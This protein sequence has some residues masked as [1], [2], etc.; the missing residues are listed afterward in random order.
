MLTEPVNEKRGLYAGPDTPVPLTGVSVEAE[1][2]GFS[3]HV[4]VTQRYVNHE[5][6]P[7]EAVYVFPLDES[8]AV[9]GFEAVIDGSVVAGEV[10]ERDEAFRDYD[11]ALAAGHGAF[12][13]DEERPDVFTASIGNLR[14][15]AEVLV[16][17]SYVAELQF[18]GDALR[19]ALPTTLSPR[20]VPA[21]H[22]HGAAGIDADRVNPPVDWNVPYGLTLSIRLALPET[23]TRIESPSHPIVVS[24]NNRIATIALSEADAPLDRDFLLLVEAPA[25][26]EPHAWI[27]RDDDGTHAIAV[28]FCPR[29]PHTA[30]PG[31]I[32]FVVDR[33]GSMGGRSIAEV[34]NAL[35]LCLRSMTPGS[36]FNIVGFGSRFETLYPASRAYD[37]ASLAAASAHVETLDAD[38]GGTEILPALQFALERPRGP[39]DRQ[40]IVLTDGQVTNTD[41][42]LALARAHADSARIFTFGIGPGASHHLVRGL[43]RAGGGAAEF[44]HPGERIEPKVVR[45]FGRIA[46]PALT[47]VRID[48]GGMTILQSPSR[49]GPVFSGGRLVAYGRTSQVAATTLRLLARSWSGPLSFDVPLDPQLTTA[50]RTVA[51]LAARERIRELEEQPAMTAR[52]SRQVRSSADCSREIIALARRY[53]LMSRETSFVAVEKRDT[54]TVGPLQ[55][56]RVPVALT[57]GWGGLWPAPPPQAVG[58]S[59]ARLS[60]TSPG[61]SPAMSC[62]DLSSRGASAVSGTVRK[63]GKAIEHLVSAV[64]TRRPA[65]APGGKPVDGGMLSVVALQHADGSWDL[66][67]EFAAALASDL[68]TLEARCPGVTSSSSDRRAWA[69]ALATAWLGRHAADRKDE[70]SVVARKARVWLDA[71]G[72][73]LTAETWLAAAATFLRV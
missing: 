15:G 42:V 43:A 28:A 60:T 7:I 45:Q 52:A 18:E 22:R 57:T 10:K 33:S 13:L 21:S 31:E 56:R 49:L 27:E 44:I 34:R 19:L 30:V 5:A 6:K 23:A 39:L 40:V 64:T 67:P 3:M 14:P 16:R 26:G 11:E 72:G 50:G 20:Y 63:A 69:T 47:E 51:T 53:N 17:L 71:N 62:A 37:D 1:V 12:L 55:L 4:R 9:C 66:T 58:R 2:T 59:F 48:W 29:L 65:A 8:A 24:W 54:P 36:R 32:V 35:Q 73:S 61:P 25:F 70:W 41:D 38:L 68:K 46:S